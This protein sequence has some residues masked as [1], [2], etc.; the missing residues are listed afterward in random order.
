MRIELES[1][2]KEKYERGYLN[3]NSEGRNVVWFTL[4]KKVV[5]GTSYARY[6]YCVHLGY[7]LSKEFE[8]DHKDN[9]KTNDEISNLQA[10][11]KEEHKLKSISEGI[12]KRVCQL[13]CPVC[14]IEFEFEVRNLSTR[15]NPCCSKKCGGIK[16]IKT[17][18]L[19]Q[20]K[21]NVEDPLISVPSV[22]PP[23]ES[24]A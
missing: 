3:V 11:T 1:P 21:H 23:P 17:K 14:A 9:D 20:G 18:L 2:Y 24:G 4:D 22:S 13:K 7:E 10:L 8:I 12:K 6:I 5:A 15:P 16:A 19:N